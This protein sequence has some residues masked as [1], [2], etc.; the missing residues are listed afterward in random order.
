MDR[1]LFEMINERFDRQENTL[2]DI[3]AAFE[4]HAAE[5]REVWREVWFVKK[6]LYGA[7]VGLLGL[8]G[9]KGLH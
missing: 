3:S 7:W 8:L 4:K 6:L 2:K 5:D 9:W 1:Q